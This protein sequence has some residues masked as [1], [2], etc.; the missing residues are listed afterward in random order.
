LSPAP[1]PSAI[2]RAKMR[3]PSRPIKGAGKA[4]ARQTPEKKLETWARRA[5]R[6][7]RILATWPGIWAVSFWSFS[8]RS[9]T[10]AWSRAP[11]SP[12]FC[13]SSSENSPHPTPAAAGTTTALM[14]M[15]R[16]KLIQERIEL[17]RWQP[18][19]RLPRWP[20]FQHV[21]WAVY[22]CPSPNAGPMIQVGTLRWLE[23][24]YILRA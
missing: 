18:L 17:R 1:A 23:C 3:Q 5:G 20:H 4:G 9:S 10:I 15:L 22:E 13:F 24:G 21:G 6:Y 7:L 11:T 16:N 2:V 14:T 8:R 12:G 19:D